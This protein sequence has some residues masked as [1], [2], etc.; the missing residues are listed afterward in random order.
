MLYFGAALMIGA[1]VYGFVDY[2]Q[3]HRKKEF[4][5]MYSKKRDPAPESVT[6]TKTQTPLAEKNEPLEKTKEV[7]KK[8]IPVTTEKVASVKP[9]APEE[10][11]VAEKKEINSTREV[12]AD[13]SPENS[14]VTVVKK[15][16]KL[17]RSL[18]SRAP[19]RE[20]EE[21]IEEPVTREEKKIEKKDL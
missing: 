16:R 5:E 4:K 8:V 11:I 20:E 19:L 1:S 18:F 6:V 13:P 7:K 12:N 3:T 14:K 10:K 2:R 9:I 15:K 17:K 21:Y